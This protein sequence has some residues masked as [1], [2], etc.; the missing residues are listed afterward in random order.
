GSGAEGQ[1]HRLGRG[2]SQVLERGQ[3]ELRAGGQRQ[4]R[5]ADSEGGQ[6]AGSQGHRVLRGW[7]R[8]RAPSEGN[9][10]RRVAAGAAPRGFLSRRRLESAP[11]TQCGARRRRKAPRMIAW[12]RAVSRRIA[13]CELSYLPRA[14]IDPDTAVAQH[15]RYVEELGALGCRVQWLP[16]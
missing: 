16:E 2:V 1:V 4:G 14:A 15:A 7:R 13:N 5:Q 12:V 8:Y 9:T 3:L 6:D 11:H 10:H